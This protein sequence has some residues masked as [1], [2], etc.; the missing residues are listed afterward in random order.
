MGSEMCIRDRPRNAR[1]FALDLDDDGGRAGALQAAATDALEA[2]GWYRP[3]KRPFWPHITLARVKRLRTHRT[4]IGARGKD[5]VAPP[6]DLIPGAL[7]EVEREEH[8]GA[9]PA[10]ACF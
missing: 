7:G 9:R 4:H 6:D 2:G 8:A 10:H 3:E 1:L 5:L